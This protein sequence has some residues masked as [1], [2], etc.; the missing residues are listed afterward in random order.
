MTNFNRDWKACDTSDKSSPY[1]IAFHAASFFMA[2][3]AF[4][5]F[6]FVLAAV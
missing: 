1:E 4:V 6:C 5:T 3:V 2:V